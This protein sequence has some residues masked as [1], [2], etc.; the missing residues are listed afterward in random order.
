MFF[1]RKLL[2]PLASNPLDPKA[3]DILAT[4]YH[5]LL[6]AVFLTWSPEHPLPSDTFGHFIQ[7]T[8]QERPSSSH[9]AEPPLSDAQVLGELL[10]DVIWTVDAQLEEVLN[11]VKSATQDQEAAPDSGSASVKEKENAEKD[12]QMLVKVVKDLLVR[13]YT[14][15]YRLSQICVSETWVCGPRPL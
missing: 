10:I 14:S 5:A 6:S 2:T 1:S 11:D 7:S 15:I 4:S 3:I 12:K 13:L 8:L 9:D